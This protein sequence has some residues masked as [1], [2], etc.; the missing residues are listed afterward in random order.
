MC[1]VERHLVYVCVCVG[2]VYGSGCGRDR[3]D[4]SLR[5]LGRSESLFVITRT[6]GVYLKRDVLFVFQVEWLIQ[7]MGWK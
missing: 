2:V 5:R 6:E 3:R 4:N 1:P 7:E